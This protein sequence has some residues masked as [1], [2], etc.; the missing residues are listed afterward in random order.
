MYISIILCNQTSS[1]R[2]K[3]LCAKQILTGGTPP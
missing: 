3:K 1:K 2:S